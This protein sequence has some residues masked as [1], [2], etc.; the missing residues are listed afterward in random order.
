MVFTKETNRWQQLTFLRR[1]K[2]GAGRS[3]GESKGGGQRRWHQQL[4]SDSSAEEVRHFSSRLSEDNT[5]SSGHWGGCHRW[6]ASNESEHTWPLYPFTYRLYTCNLLISLQAAFCHLVTHLS[7]HCIDSLYSTW[8][9]S[10]YICTISPRWTCSY[11][12]TSIHMG[13]VIHSR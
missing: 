9:L 13:T 4:W 10:M 2:G 11:N 7:S 5:A 6:A 12:S 8:C 1:T 3:L